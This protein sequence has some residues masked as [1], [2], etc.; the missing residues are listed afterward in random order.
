MSITFNERVKHHLTEL[1]TSPLLDR[2]T[3]VDALLDL[4]NTTEDP[5]DRRRLEES[6]ARL[7]RAVVL[8]RVAVADALLD[9]LDAG[10]PPSLN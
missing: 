1:A 6:L 7:P 8:D 10:D 4:L 2:G 3:V 5:D 9:L